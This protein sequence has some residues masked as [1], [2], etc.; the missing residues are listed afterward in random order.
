[1]RKNLFSIYS[2]KEAQNL[3]VFYDNHQIFES[4]KLD[5]INNPTF[6][7]ANSYIADVPSFLYNFDKTNFMNPSDA[8]EK[9]TNKNLRFV[10][11]WRVNS[12]CTDALDNYFAS[13][14]GDD[15]RRMIQSDYRHGRF[16][17]AHVSYHNLNFDDDKIGKHIEKMM[18][19]SCYYATSFKDYT[20]SSFNNS[21][22]TK[23]TIIGI[24]HNTS[25]VEKLK[26]TSELFT[27]MFRRKAYL[28][29]FT[30]V[31]MD[32]MEFTEAE[33]NIHDIVKKYE[34]AQDEE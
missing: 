7:G 29:W 10:S 31:G 27:C 5:G 22:D 16:L 25:I 12:D 1:M 24:A 30:G 9:L 15:N 20:S 13:F 18:D 17:N 19:S 14:L 21:K 32:E 3:T 6:C 28:H 26:I 33:S 2:I 11:S 8:C 23:K 34:E 4:M